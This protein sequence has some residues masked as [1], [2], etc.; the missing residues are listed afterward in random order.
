MIDARR[1]RL[2]Q[3]PL[4]QGGEND[5]AELMTAAEIIMRSNEAMAMAAPYVPMT[6]AEIIVR[7]LRYR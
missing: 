5:D 6:A 3:V 4:Y 7:R 1:K 2:S